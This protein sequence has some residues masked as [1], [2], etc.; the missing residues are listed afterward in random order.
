MATTYTLIDK[1]T[2]GSNQSSITFS[3]IPSTYTDLL[4]KVSLRSDRTEVDEVAYFKPNNSTTG[5]SYKRLRGNG[6]GAG[7]SSDNGFYVNGN[8][9]TS[10]SFSN[11]ELYLP[12]YASSNFKSWSIDAVMENNATEAYTALTAGLW[13]NTAAI[14]S[15]V[16]TP[17]F[18]SNWVTNS[19]AYL[20]GI[21]NS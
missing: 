1:T 5:L 4:L 19:S 16:I 7:S 6:T 2:L 3:S 14:T 18:G 10:N 17:V 11:S 12:N 21:K 9:T 20:Y 8:T 15:I 13:S